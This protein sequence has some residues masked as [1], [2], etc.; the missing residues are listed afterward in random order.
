MPDYIIIFFYFDLHSSF[1]MRHDF[2]PS[3]FPRFTFYLIGLN[4]LLNAPFSDTLNLCHSLWFRRQVS[5]SFTKNNIYAF[6]RILNFTVYSNTKVMNS[7]ATSV[8][9]NLSALNCVVN[10]I[11]I[12]VVTKYLD[13]CANYLQFMTLFAFCYMYLDMWVC[14]MF[15]TF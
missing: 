6:S 5:C 4:S 14:L 7:M 15:C 12:Y 3:S 1:M 10:A 2:E 13:W 11:L 8:P 9:R